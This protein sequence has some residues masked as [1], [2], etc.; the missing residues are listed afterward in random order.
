MTKLQ[1]ECSYIRADYTQEEEEI[2]RH[3][4]SV[5]YLLSIGRFRYM[6]SHA[7]R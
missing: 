5:E 7:E 2:Q 6:A 4:A 3:S 1:G